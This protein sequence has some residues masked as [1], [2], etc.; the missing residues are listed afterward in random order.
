MLTGVWTFTVFDI[1][2]S[3]DPVEETDEIYLA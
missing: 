2:Q 3:S 1:S